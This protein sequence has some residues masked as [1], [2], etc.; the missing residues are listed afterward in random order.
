MKKLLLL[1]LYAAIGGGLYAQISDFPEVDYCM[2]S[3]AGFGQNATGGGNGAVVTVKTHT[4]LKAALK[5][6][7]ASVI[8]VTADITFGEGSMIAETITNKTLLGLKGVK[9]ISTAQVKNGG[10]L[11]LKAGSNNVIIR[12]L[13]FEGPGAYDVDGQD[14]LSN[15]GCQNLWVD[16]C[17]FYD[18]VDGN[19]DNTNSADNVSISWCKFG[20]NK[21]PKAGGDGGSNDHRFSNLIGGSES[22]APADGHYSITFQFCYWSEGCK[23]R[24]PR[25]R[26]AE[27]H[28][29][30]CYYKVAA[31][32]TTALGLE[33]GT[34]GLSCYVEATHFKQVGT[35]YKNYD[36][37]NSLPK[38][39]TFVD[40][41]ASK[42][43]PANIGTAPRPGY[44]YSVLPAEQVEPAV[45]S[46][47]GAGATLNVTTSGEI[48]S[49]TS[50]TQ[51][52]SEKI[53]KLVTYYD[54][55]G[56]PVKATVKGFVIVKTVYTD[57]TSST[58]KVYL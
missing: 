36:A 44:A 35:I 49:P 16:H 54:L 51:P 28:I 53:V 55:L 9:L 14:L 45:T 41:L 58:R 24:M 15:T 38:T 56:R 31:S 30:N 3:P 46:D 19:F 11:N 48:S 8:V 17:E 5:A 37:S 40:C 18:G 4:E 23:E 52:A 25:A 12:N 29:L 26:N 2:T 34:K 22:A 32:G 20:Y 7:G 39:L 21:P 33:G 50:I 57:G 10:I 42:A 6:S 47:R 13:I 27:L 43:I 1:F